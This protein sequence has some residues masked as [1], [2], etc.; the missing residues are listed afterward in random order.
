M[1]EYKSEL[2]EKE[3]PSSFNYLEYYQGLVCPDLSSPQFLENTAGTI[4]FLRQG[5]IIDEAHI[6]REVFEAATY[7]DD[8][9]QNEEYYRNIQSVCMES[10]RYM[11]RI[12]KKLTKIKY[13]G[14]LFQAYCG[15][16]DGATLFLSTTVPGWRGSINSEWSYVIDENED[17][18]RGDRLRVRLENI[19]CENERQVLLGGLAYILFQVETLAK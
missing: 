10:R 14:R 3:P 18:V 5:E 2:S 7:P 15:G 12:A 1:N 8:I 17:I 19:G 4:Q 13:Q 11:A 16:G 9:L 6:A